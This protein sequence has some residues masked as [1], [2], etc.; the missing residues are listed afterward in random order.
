MVI[1]TP[2][3]EP[4]TEEEL[5][6]FV[7]AASEL[8]YPHRLIAH[9][10]PYTGLSASE[11]CHLRREWIVYR[12]EGEASSSD[13]PE[14]LIIHVPEESPCTGTLWHPSESRRR[15]E[16]REEP[17]VQCKPDGVWT[18]YG[19]RRV[20]RIP[21]HEPIA[22]NTIRKWFGRYDSV[23]LSAES[24]GNHRWMDEILEEANLSREIGWRGL[25]NTYAL[26]LVSKGFDSEMIADVF[27]L[28]KR[29]LLKP[30]FERAGR[31]IDW[32]EK[33][34]SVGRVELLE[35]FRRVT[36]E[37]GY[38]PRPAEIDEH[39]E[40]SRST[41]KQRFEDWDALC[42]AAGI[43]PPEGQIR[44]VELIQ[45]LRRLTDELGHPP[46]KKEINEL[47]EFSYATYLSRF[48]GIEAAR[49]A[50]G[51]GDE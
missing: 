14:P 36:D 26:L 25:R 29:T 33:P 24:T 51:I 41:Y 27:G 11:F 5:E 6:P 12:E 48:D 42:E 15:I 19:D 32:Q 22:I 47:G 2:K 8:D 31:P 10:V 3:A 45:E 9:I 30:I 23:P 37:L 18:P 46:Q 44:T 16:S 35:E 7:E 34:D 1:T 20:R 49:E 21:V 38:P 43:D 50:A 40:Y 28:P 4:L 13:D 39:A 17:C